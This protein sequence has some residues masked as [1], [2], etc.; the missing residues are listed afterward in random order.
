MSSGVWSSRITNRA[1]W[2]FSNLPKGTSGLAKFTWPGA[3]F[4]VASNALRP[5]TDLRFKRAANI[6]LDWDVISDDA[7]AYQDLLKFQAEIRSE[8]HSRQQ[9]FEAAHRL[10]V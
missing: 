1:K 8:V 7:A 5:P 3:K 4:I 2:R 6:K 9:R 10:A